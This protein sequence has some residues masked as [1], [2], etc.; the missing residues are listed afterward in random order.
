MAREEPPDLMV[1]DVMM[2]GMDGLEL[3]Q[4]LRADPDLDYLPVILLTA[5]AA[6]DDL[7]EG[8]GGGADAYVTKP[9]EPRELRV[10][11]D[12]ILDARRRLRERWAEGGTS[13]PVLQVP[14]T[15][16]DEPDRHEAFVA[17]MYGA[18]QE[19]LADEDFG[20]EQLASALHMS[21]AT[22]YRRVRDATDGSPLDAIQGY[23]L[24][25]AALWLVETEANVSEVAYGVGFRSVPHFSSRFKNR[26]G[27]TPTE[28]RRQR[29]GSR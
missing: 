3:V 12:R 25:Q 17:A 21:R 15:S 28:Y 27:A 16:R 20:V 22:L 2:P 23:R 10:R 13:L 24:E 1:S 4:A 7:I 19:H 14:L 11:I 8:I 9:F 18:I 6:K 29:R 5:R 26:F